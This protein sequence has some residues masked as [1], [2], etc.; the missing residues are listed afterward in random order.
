M[1]IFILIEALNETLVNE[2]TARN[3]GAFRRLFNYLDN[4]R[5]MENTNFPQNRGGTSFLSI[6][7]LQYRPAPTDNCGFGLQ[8]LTKTLLDL[9]E[10]TLFLSDFNLNRNMWTEFIVNPQYQ[11]SCKSTSFFP[12]IKNICTYRKANWRTS[13]IRHWKIAK[14]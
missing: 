9:S 13:K 6:A 8:I 2:S 3:S 14:N 7:L 10:C 11:C 12:L 4:H 5:F 1:Q